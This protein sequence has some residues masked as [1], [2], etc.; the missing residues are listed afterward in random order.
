[1]SSNL[2]WST[3]VEKLCNTLRQRI[4]I[5]KRITHIVPVSKL[6]IVAE[7]IFT[8]KIRYAIAVY[9]NPRMGEEESMNENL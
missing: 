7:A 6:E 3:H 8:S 4:G 2:D 5:L 1:M 9:L